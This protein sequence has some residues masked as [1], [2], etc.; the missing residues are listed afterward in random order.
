MLY[1]IVIYNRYR[2]GELYMLHKSVL[3]KEV[4]DNLKIKSNGIYVDATLGYA[5][6][7]SEILKRIP[8]GFLYGID[9]D[10]YAISCSKKKLSSISDNYHI[11]RSNFANMKSELLKLG[12]NKVDG[13]LFDLGVS[14]VQ[15]D[16]ASRGFSFHKDAK[17][18]MRMDT[19]SNFSAYNVVNEY[20]YKDLVRILRDYGEEKYA[21]SIAKNIVKS[22]NIKPIETT[23]ELVDIIKKSM[24]MKAMRD[25]HPARRSFQAI[26]IEVNHEL[27]VLDIALKHALELLNVGGRLCVISFHSLED[28]LVKDTFKEYSEISGNFKKLPYV[29]E[30]YLPKYKVIGKSIVASVEEL[31]DNYRAHSARLRVIERIKD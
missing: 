1:D 23:F 7:S 15:I 19:S 25:G 24:P 12:I 29:P 16:E 27:E 13:I 9:Q 4:I 2:L 30:E 11:I 10:D 26:R 17:L 18:D 21:S 6:H 22:R 20:D 31:E 8:D 5:G 28:R 3:L 14:S